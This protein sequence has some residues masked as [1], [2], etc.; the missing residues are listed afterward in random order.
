MALMLTMLPM[1]TPSTLVITEAMT[2]T[3]DDLM[4]HEVEEEDEISL[5]TNRSVR[6]IG[7][8]DT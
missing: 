1:R 3:V 7:N 5:R 4:I 2:I 8:V 6:S